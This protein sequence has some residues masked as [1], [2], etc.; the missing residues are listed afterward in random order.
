L[1]GG[2]SPP[3]P[4]RGDGTELYRRLHAVNSRFVASLVVHCCALKKNVIFAS[5]LYDVADE[6]YSSQLRKKA[7][8][9]FCSLFK[10]I[11]LGT[12]FQI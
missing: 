2:L 5:Q 7:P 12:L 4:P 9:N 10:S 8:L 11:T 3:K 1:F 6:G